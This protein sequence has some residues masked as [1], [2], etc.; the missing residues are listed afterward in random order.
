MVDA[1]DHSLTYVN[2]GTAIFDALRLPFMLYANRNEEVTLAPVRRKYE[3][4][5]QDYPLL[6]GL[7]D[8]RRSWRIVLPNLEQCALLQVDYTDLDEIAAEDAFW[9]DMPLLDGLTPVDR[10]EFIATILDFFRLGIRH[11]QRELSDPGPHRRERQTLP[12]NAACPL[13]A[14]CAT[15]TCASPM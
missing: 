5:L 10:R 13:D 2:V 12:R 14:G 11:Q 1:P 9:S 4:A 3:Q 6:P 15:R 8:L 7:A